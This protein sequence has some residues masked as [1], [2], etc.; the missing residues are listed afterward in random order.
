MKSEVRQKKNM[1][2]FLKI[3]RCFD[4]SA[5]FSLNVRD[6]ARAVSSTVRDFPKTRETRA[7]RAPNAALELHVL[8]ADIF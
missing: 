1:N 7:N 4:K 6:P 8:L 5:G 2:F 3:T